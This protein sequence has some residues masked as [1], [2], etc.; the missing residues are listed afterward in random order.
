MLRPRI[1]IPIHWGTL[2]RIDLSR[3]ANEI[4]HTPPRRFV[5][6]LAERAPA[7]E[8][9]VLEPG[10]SLEL[11]SR[12]IPTRRSSPWRSWS[13]CVA[14]PWSGRDVAR[15]RSGRR[16]ARR[17]P[18]ARRS[19]RA[20]RAAGRSAPAASGSTSA[21]SPSAGISTWSGLREVT[22]STSWSP[23]WAEIVG[24]LAAPALICSL[25]SSPESACWRFESWSSFARSRAALPRPGPA[26]RR[27]SRSR[28]G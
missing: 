10:E 14:W 16:C 7:I 13:R 28:A 11:S 22:V 8:P 5:A 3:R 27:C 2:L 15:S 20:R 24:G 26:R 17:R 12:P 19:G 9:A 23:T 4:L 18:G 1:A 6:Q 21:S 25:T